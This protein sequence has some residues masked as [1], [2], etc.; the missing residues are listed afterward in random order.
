PIRNYQGKV[1]AAVSVSVPAFRIDA[2]KQNNLKKALIQTSKKISG[3]LGY[4]EK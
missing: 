1:I 2:D 3:R 4:K